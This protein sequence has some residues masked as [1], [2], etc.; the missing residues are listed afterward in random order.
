MLSQDPGFE[1]NNTME[2]NEATAVAEPAAEQAKDVTVHLVNSFTVD[3]QD[4]Y[5]L[6]YTGDEQ[7]HQD[8]MGVTIVAGNDRLWIP[9]HNIA[10]IEVT[11]RA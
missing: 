6:S 1:R 7:I 10:A 4:V 2:T 11:P 5:T 9:N 8:A 3:G